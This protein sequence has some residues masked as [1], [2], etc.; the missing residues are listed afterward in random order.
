MMRTRGSAAGGRLAACVSGRGWRVAHASFG[1]DQHARA[2]LQ[3]PDGVGAR[4]RRPRLRRAGIDRRGAQNADW[5]LTQ[6]TADGWFELY[7]PRDTAPL[8]HTIAYTLEGLVGIGATLGEERFVDAARRGAEPLARLVAAN[9][10]LAGSVRARL[11][12]PDTSWACLT[13]D[14]QIAIVFLRLARAL[15]DCA[16]YRAFAD[17]LLKGVA[18]GQDLN[19]PYPETRGAIG[20]SAPIWGG[21][22]RFAYPNWAA[23]FFMDALLLALYDDDVGAPA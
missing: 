20:G 10:R 18:A 5:T 6:Q 12:Q 19:S 17:T 1:A 9:G 4:A 15:D 8:L 13:G 16:P 23:K 3:R 22:L 21:Y 14:A 11:R 7:V 2:D